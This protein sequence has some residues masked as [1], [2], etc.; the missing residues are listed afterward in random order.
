MPGSGTPQPPLANGKKVN[1]P[2]S[3]T[4]QPRITPWQAAKT[5]Y[6]PGARTGGAP[7]KL[8]LAVRL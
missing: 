8:L 5:I 3:R 6:Q 2:G 1:L 7:L 4:Q